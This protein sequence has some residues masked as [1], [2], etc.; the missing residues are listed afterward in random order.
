MFAPHPYPMP[1]IGEIEVKIVKIILDVVLKVAQAIGKSVIELAKNMEAFFKEIGVLDTDTNLDQLSDKAFVAEKD[2]DIRPE[3]FETYEEYRAAVDAVDVSEERAAK[4]MDDERGMQ[5][6]RLL[7]EAAITRLGSPLTQNLML[8][9]LHHEDFFQNGK[10]EALGK[11][12]GSNL[13]AVEAVAGYINGKAQS[14]EQSDLAFDRL[15]AG[16]KY[17][18]PTLSAEDAMKNVMALRDRDEKREGR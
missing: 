11:V 2:H 13:E 3:N 5:A 1:Q 16:E 18:N 7:A 14:T 12:L 9:V 15:L 17:A 8:A 10:L 6:F 4:I